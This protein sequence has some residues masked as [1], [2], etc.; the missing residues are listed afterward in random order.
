MHLKEMIIAYQR[1]DLRILKYGKVIQY[2]TMLTRNDACCS[3]ASALLWHSDS[4]SP[5]H[6]G[7]RL[8]STL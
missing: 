7:E 4:R 3:V 5:I 2:N 6:A 8:H 1:P